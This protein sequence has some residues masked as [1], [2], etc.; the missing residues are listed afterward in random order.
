MTVQMSPAQGQTL[1][2]LRHARQGQSDIDTARMAD[3]LAAIAPLEKRLAEH[4][5]Y[6][7]MSTLE[8]VQVFMSHHI[9]AVWDFMTLL[10]SLQGRLTSTTLPWRPVGD[11]TTRRLI[12]EIVLSEESDEFG[13]G[14]YASHYEIYL[15]AMSQ[16]GASH[17]SIQSLVESWETSS[18]AA[19]VVAA[20]ELPESV[21]DFISHTWRVAVTLEDHSVAAAFALGRE[22]LLPTLFERLVASLPATAASSLTGLQGY[23]NRHIELDGEVHNTLSLRMLSLLCGDDDQKW[24]DA[25]VVA[26]TSLEVRIALWDGVVTELDR[27]LN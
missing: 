23:L 21:R 22:V 19:D 9:F 5:V 18:S 26:Q 20:A 4:P 17:A 7:R 12:N 27:K 1:E 13:T 2:S 14:Q 3:L 24:K 25:L 10:K 15:Q 11:G 16:A 6:D 8:D